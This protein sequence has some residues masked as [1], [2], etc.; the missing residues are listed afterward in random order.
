MVIKSKLLRAPH[1]FSTR[2]GGVSEAEHTKSM[3][4]AFGRGDNDETVLENLELFAAEAGVCARE[5]ISL[6]QIHSNIVHKV[7]EADAGLGYYRRDCINERIREGD[8]YITNRHGVTLGVKSADCVPILF[9]AYDRDRIIAVGAVHA[10]W[11]GTVGRIAQ[12]CVDMLCM[13]Y[14]IVPE[15]IR[16]SIGPCIHKCCFE[17]GEDVYLKVVECVG[18]ENA[19]KFITPKENIP[20]K[21]LC[22]LPGINKHILLSRGLSEENVEIIDYCTYDH[23]EL[24]YSHRYSNG[25]RGTMLSA[26]SLPRRER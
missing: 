7:T 18:E 19:E 20:D 10:G 11:R 4:L 8:G 23:P 21:F 25:K 22:D 5:I 12:N 1:A 26:I 14:G 15:N 6:P 2:L 13:H 9:E 16:A 17:V 3:N 24:F